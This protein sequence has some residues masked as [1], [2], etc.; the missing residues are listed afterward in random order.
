M[1]FQIDR[2]RDALRLEVV[3]DANRWVIYI[4]K[5][6]GLLIEVTIPR[7][8]LEWFV[9]ASDETGTVWS[10]WADHYATNGETLEELMAEMA[11]S[12]EQFLSIVV[13]SEVRVS[14]SGPESEKII[15]FKVDTV[16]RSASFIWM[17]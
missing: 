7:D 3:E 2:L 14:H 6:A 16:W 8:V 4:R 15:E 17:T 11:T 1:Q 13:N 5:P 10:E 9:S 12:I